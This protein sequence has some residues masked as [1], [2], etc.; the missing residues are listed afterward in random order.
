M[1]ENAAEARKNDTRN[2]ARVRHEQ[3]A[4][5]Q[6]LFLMLYKEVDIDQDGYPRQVR[7]VTGKMPYFMTAADNSGAA[8]ASR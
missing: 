4:E 5:A 2:L 1:V 7:D 3:R 8:V 6:E